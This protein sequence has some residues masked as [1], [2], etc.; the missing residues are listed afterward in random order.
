MKVTYSS[1]NLQCGCATG[2]SENRL[3][4]CGTRL[5]KS[6]Q[7]SGAIDSRAARRTW[8]SPLTALAARFTWGYAH[9][10]TLSMQIR[11]S[12]GIA[13]LKSRIGN[14]RNNGLTCRC[15]SDR[16][17]PVGPLRVVAPAPLGSNLCFLR[18]PELDLQVAD[19]DGCGSGRPS[20]PAGG[21]RL[22]GRAFY[23][24][25]SFWLFTPGLRVSGE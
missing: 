21:L 14:P 20:S 15:P 23:L 18:N 13:P 4:A 8:G 19:P 3:Q 17:Q 10:G 7:G 9:A 1:A 12:R 16:T 11:Q 22:P 24:R 6:L 25:P 2:R 5:T